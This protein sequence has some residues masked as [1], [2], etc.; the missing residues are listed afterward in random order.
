MKIEI[1]KNSK[2]CWIRI[3]Y[4]H[5]LKSQIQQTQLQ[6]PIKERSRKSKSKDEIYKT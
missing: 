2:A 4:H 3:I 5:K 6:R 1:N